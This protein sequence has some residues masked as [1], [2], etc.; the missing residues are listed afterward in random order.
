MTTLTIKTVTAAEAEPTI[1]TRVLAV[2][3]DPLARWIERDPSPWRCTLRV[4]G[5]YHRRRWLYCNASAGC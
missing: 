5:G 1:A 2:S 3:A 4:E